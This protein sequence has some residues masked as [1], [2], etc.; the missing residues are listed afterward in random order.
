MV[1]KKEPPVETL[2]I[3]VPE[4][5]SA[6]LQ[7]ETATRGCNSASECVVALLEEAQQRQA[8]QQLERLLLEGLQGQKTEI[9][10]GW[11]ENFRGRLAQNCQPKKS[12]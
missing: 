10:P 8:E 1:K 6:F 11:W 12:S 5:L 9:T 4:S 3:N 2:Q 7:T